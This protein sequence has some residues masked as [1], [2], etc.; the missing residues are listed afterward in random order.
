MIKHLLFLSTDYHPKFIFVGVFSNSENIHQAKFY[1]WIL[2]VKMLL[3]FMPQAPPVY[4]S[5]RSENVALDN[6]LTLDNKEGIQSAE[7]PQK[8]H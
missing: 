2:Y 4:L 3:F 6:K 5:V 1:A 8:H 7:Q